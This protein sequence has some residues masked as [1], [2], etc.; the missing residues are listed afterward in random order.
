MK[1][2]TGPIVFLSTSEKNRRPSLC[3]HALLYNAKGRKCFALDRV[4]LIKTWEIH[5]QL[6]LIWKR[7][8]ASYTLLQV[9]QIFDH[10]WSKL[11]NFFSRYKVQW[12]INFLRQFTKL[13]NYSFSWRKHANILSLFSAVELFVCL[14]LYYFISFETNISPARSRGFMIVQFRLTVWRKCS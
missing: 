7:F 4:N 3:K 11:N 14:P 5:L 8:M 13:W 1:R 9:A 10:Q 2:E 6:H 12:S